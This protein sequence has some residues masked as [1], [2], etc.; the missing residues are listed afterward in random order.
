MARYYPC[1]PNKLYS[2]WHFGYSTLPPESVWGW[3]VPLAY[4]FLSLM[5][6]SLWYPYSLTLGNSITLLHTSGVFFLAIILKGISNFGKDA[7][8]RKMLL[9]LRD[10]CAKKKPLHSRKQSRYNLIRSIEEKKKDGG[11]HSIGENIHRRGRVN[12]KKTVHYWKKNL[13]WVSLGDTGWGLGYPRTGW[14]QIWR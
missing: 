11:T 5:S 2:D 13:N 9:L 12:V 4:N 10:K 8:T 1:D 7:N 3:S 6:Q 14:T